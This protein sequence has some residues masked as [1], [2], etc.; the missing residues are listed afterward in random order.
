MKASGSQIKNYADPRNLVQ[1][2]RQQI[3]MQICHKPLKTN[4]YTAFR[5]DT[6]RWIVVRQA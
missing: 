2:Q 3:Q 4:P 5:D 6:G 1:L